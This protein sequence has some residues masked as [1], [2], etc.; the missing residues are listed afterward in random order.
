MNSSYSYVF[1]M[2]AQPNLLYIKKI[3]NK[4]KL[5]PSPTC[6]WAR[7]SENVLQQ[8]VHSF[9]QEKPSK[10]GNLVLWEK[11]KRQCMSVCI[12]LPC[13]TMLIKF[14]WD[15][16]QFHRRTFKHCALS[17]TTTL[18]S[19]CAGLT[20]CSSRLNTM[21]VTKPTRIAIGMRLM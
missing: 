21:S 1:V 20:V 17:K 19:T 12:L 16:W 10:E 4:K 7:L 14:L 13:L 18:S 6:A 2:L 9:I 11:K 3:K 5:V 15:N 8:P